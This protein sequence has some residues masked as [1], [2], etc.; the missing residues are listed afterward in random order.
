MRRTLLFSIA[1]LVCLLI[2][3]G[4]WFGL[5]SLTTAATPA[6]LDPDT[7]AVARTFVDH[8]DAGRWDDAHAMLA[9]A[10]ASALTASR[11]A[12]VWDTLPERLGAPGARGP[13]R[14]ERIG[15]R[16]VTT[17]TQD[18]AMTP[19]DIRVAVD[20]DGHIDGFRVVPAA[21]RVDAGTLAPA[22]AGAVEHAVS[23]GA[24]ALPGTLLLP[25]GEAP[26]PAVVLVHGSGP[27]DRDGT[28]GP[29]RPLRDIAHGLAERGIA[30]LRYDK[31]SRSAPDAF[32]GSFT[33][34][35]EVVDDA[36]A[37]VALL[38]AH[39]AID[40]AR[41]FVLG[42]SLGA[43]MAP[44]IGARAPEVA[45]LILAAAPARPLQ[46]VYVAQIALL[47][48]LDGETS[49][50]EQAAIDDAR[51]RAAAVADLTADSPA[52]ENLLGLPGA[53][54]VDLRDY[55]PVETARGLPQPLLVL[56]GGRDYQVTP[57]D[58]YARWQ[59]AF[60]DDPR[61]TLRLHPA[62]NHLLIAGEGPPGPAEYAQAGTVD[63]A[64]LDDVAAWIGDVRVSGSER[65]GE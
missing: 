40:P 9:P 44:R 31:R 56:Q 7:A 46:D 49:A 18:F 52:G 23:L 41:V 16:L 2:G 39:E 51:A 53:Y 32:G 54:W 57:D 62:L 45:G 55:D 30:S 34:D 8:L 14:G 11:L 63:G 10:V 59:A 28:V 33:V 17:A 35:D 19:I 4:F 25:A 37:A 50:E 38:R 64:L 47:A 26:F 13:W 65:S 58:D 27:Q 3:A 43:Q 29:N 15:S 5:R 48:G 60:G 12:E 61:A 24:H 36:L 20:A 22:P 21:V 1:A 42:H 6:E